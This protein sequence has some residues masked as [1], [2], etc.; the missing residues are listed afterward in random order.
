MKKDFHFFLPFFG[1]LA[2]IF[3]GVLSFPEM[4]KTGNLNF[5]CPKLK[6]IKPSTLLGII[7]CIYIYVY[8]IYKSLQVYIKPNPH[9]QAAKWLDGALMGIAFDAGGSNRRCGATRSG[10]I[11][12]L[13][14]I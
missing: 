1:H 6:Y 10:E 9:L 14:P 2:T 5:N 3:Q 12:H 13:V 4:I 7:I 11:Q 8:Y